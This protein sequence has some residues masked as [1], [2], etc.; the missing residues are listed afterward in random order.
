MADAAV[1]CVP[2]T[3]LGSVHS[4]ADAA[5]GGTPLVQSGSVQLLMSPP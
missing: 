2:L 1:G 4:M 5:T 3:H